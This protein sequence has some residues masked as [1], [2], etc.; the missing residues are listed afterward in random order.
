MRIEK[1]KKKKSKDNDNKK[2][3]SGLEYEIFKIME[4]S[5][6]AALDAAVDDLLKDWK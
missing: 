1:G 3:S 4:K 5:M 2:K 6:K